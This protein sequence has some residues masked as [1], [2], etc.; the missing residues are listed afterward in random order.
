MFSS[1]I[2]MTLTPFNEI[3]DENE[4]EKH[5][6]YMR[7][8]LEVADEAFNQREV[9]VLATAQHPTLIRFIGATDK[10]PFCIATE[11]MSNGSLFSSIHHY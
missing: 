3:T 6:K 11:W 2:I 10:E 9:A 8:A 4:R 5:L 7:I 1:K